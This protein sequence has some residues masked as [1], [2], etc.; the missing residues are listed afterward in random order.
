MSEN[1][2]MKHKNAYTKL[3]CSKHQTHTCMQHTHH[4]RDGRKV[5]QTK[6]AK[7]ENALKPI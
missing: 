2:C 1:L 7:L 6:G 4:S 3:A 5:S